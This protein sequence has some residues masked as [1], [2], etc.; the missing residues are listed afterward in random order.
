MD[1][2]NTVPILET[3]KNYCYQLN[4]HYPSVWKHVAANQV[5]EFCYFEN[6][7]NETVK[8]SKSDSMRHL[9]LDSPNVMIIDSSNVLKYLAGVVMVFK[10]T[11]IVYCS[12]TTRYKP[13]Q[14]LIQYVTL[15]YL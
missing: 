12:R 3:A 15:D 7:Y 11:I 5:S 9:V 2:H 6:G 10:R 1:S 8:T 4:T 13:M 14:H